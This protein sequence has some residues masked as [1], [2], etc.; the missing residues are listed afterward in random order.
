VLINSAG[1]SGTIA[2]SSNSKSDMQSC[3]SDAECP[4]GAFTLCAT[5]F[6]ALPLRCCKPMGSYGEWEL[7]RSVQMVQPACLWI[8]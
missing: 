6:R 7:C 4:I 8:L 2:R 5:G 1:V 3:T